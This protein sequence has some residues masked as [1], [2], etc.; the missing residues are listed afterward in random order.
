[1][2]IKRIIDFVSFLNEL[3]ISTPEPILDKKLEID[4]AIK[5]G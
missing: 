2:K 4:V 3:N 1:M 5:N